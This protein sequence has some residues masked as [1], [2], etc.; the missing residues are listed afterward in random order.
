M[1]EQEK[2]KDYKA[3]SFIWLIFR[4]PRI[5]FIIIFMLLLLN[6]FYDTVSIDSYRELAKTIFPSLFTLGSLILALKFHL[7]SYLQR[8]L[9]DTPEYHKLIFEKK[10]NEGVYAPLQRIVEV[11]QITMKISIIAAI[12]NAGTIIFSYYLY[13]SFTIIYTATA[14]YFIILTLYIYTKAIKD[15]Q[16]VLSNKSK[17]LKDEYN[18]KLD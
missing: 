11:L 7:V 16:W 10:L 15:L 14:L 13:L 1:C 5:L 3:N 2:I 12:F 8:E 18:Q 17:L 9:Y 6:C 4:I